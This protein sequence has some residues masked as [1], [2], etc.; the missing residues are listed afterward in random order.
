MDIRTMYRLM[1]DLFNIREE[2]VLLFEQVYSDLTCEVYNRQCHSDIVKNMVED[3]SHG[4][5]NMY[6]EI[7]ITIGDEIQ[8][9]IKEYEKAE[10][11]EESTLSLELGYPYS[12]ETVI[13]LS[14]SEIE[15]VK[16]HIFFLTNCNPFCAYPDFY[17][18]NELDTVVDWESSVRNNAVAYI[19]HVVKKERENLAQ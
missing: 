11:K 9:L 3:F 6:S 8:A 2:H 10:D 19:K 4:M 14:E 7:S 15:K 18:N 1:S 12:G 5:H 13:P 17:F 16:E